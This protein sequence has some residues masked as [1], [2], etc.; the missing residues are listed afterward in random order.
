MIVR[1]GVHL[2]QMGGRKWS[3]CGNILDGTWETGR[4]LEKVS[5]REWKYEGIGE[6]NEDMSRFWARLPCGNKFRQDKDVVSP[7]RAGNLNVK[8]ADRNVARH[9]GEG[10][11]N[12]VT[13]VLRSAARMTRK[14]AQQ[15]RDTECP[16]F[17]AQ[18]SFDHLAKDR[19]HDFFESE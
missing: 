2:A 6:Q 11:S 12:V 18:P 7:K 15:R 3:A 8:T 13:T 17:N 14:H 1:Y 4:K 9:E 5:D 19:D 16:T 10:T